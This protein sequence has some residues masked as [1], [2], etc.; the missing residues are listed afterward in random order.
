MTTTIL[1]ESKTAAYEKLL[2]ELPVTL[3]NLIPDPLIQWKNTLEKLESLV[4]T[5]HTGPVSIIT[6]GALNPKK[7]E[8]LKEFKNKGLNLVVLCSISELQEMEAAPMEPRYKNIKLL[9]EVGVPA[10]GYIRPLMPPHNTDYETLTKI[11]KNLRDAGCKA[12]VVSGFR[13]DENL[14]EKMGKTDKVKHVLRVKLMYQDLWKDVLELSKEFEV[15]L[16]T[17]TSCAVDFLLGNH[18]TFNP[19]Y[20]SPKL[21][22]CKEVNCPIRETCKG[23]TEPKKDSLDFL[24][25]L[26]YDVVFEKGNGCTNL[27]QVSP[28]NRTKCKSCCTTCYFLEGNPRLLVKG[29]VNLA[30]L[31]F[32]RFLSG[33]TAQQP[34]VN[35]TGSKDIAN[36]RFPNFPE[37]FGKVQVQNT[38]WVMANSKESKCY[39]CK[40]CIVEGYYNEY[41]SGEVGFAPAELFSI[42]LKEKK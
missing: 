25:L 4:K 34:G 29:D 11:F 32:I 24:S 21:A 41:E 8:L 26:G 18:V 3:N 2:R 10:I 37:L 13:G 28:D 31:S 33:I 14:I 5:G 39:A 42:L 15:Q 38:W 16:F 19:Y 22:K 20:N 40:Y 9:N 35:D 6:K 27:C 36:V 12:A 1:P 30:D 17:R 23:P 7:C